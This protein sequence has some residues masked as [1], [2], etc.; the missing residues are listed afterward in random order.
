MGGYKSGETFLSITIYDEKEKQP[1][2]T[3]F[4]F[5]FVNISFYQN[6]YGKEIG[7]I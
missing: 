6:L 7:N 2:I 3:Q 5:Y 4:C 1:T